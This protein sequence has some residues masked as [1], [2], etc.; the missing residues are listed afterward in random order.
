MLAGMSLIKGGQRSFELIENQLDAGRSSA[1]LVRLLPDIDAVR[2]R[3]VLQK[4]LQGEPGE[5]VE[6]A[7]QCIDLLDRIDRLDKKE[8]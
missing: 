6:T 5:I 1:S 7:K 3:A 4:V 2:A 8:L